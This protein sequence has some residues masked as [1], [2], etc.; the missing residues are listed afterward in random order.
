MGSKMYCYA[1]FVFRFVSYLDSS[2]KYDYNSKFG[3]NFTE[4]R[5]SF[6]FDK[7]G[8]KFFMWPFDM[9]LSIEIKND[10]ICRYNI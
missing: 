9:I 4:T 10:K 1:N 3:I 7:L 5:F 8:I 6:N 2:L